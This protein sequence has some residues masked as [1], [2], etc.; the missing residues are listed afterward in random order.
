MK[1]KSSF[2]SEHVIRFGTSG[3]I[4]VPGSLLG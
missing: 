1:Q 4:I 3:V 2:S